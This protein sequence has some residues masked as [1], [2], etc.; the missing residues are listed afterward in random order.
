LRKFLG[1]TSAFLLAGLTLFGQQYNIRTVAGGAPIPN[2]PS[3]SNASIGNPG[4]MAADPAGNIYFITDDCVFRIDTGGGLTR[5]AGN[6]Q[7]GFSGDG[8]PAVQA[9]LNN[10]LGLAVDS[11]NNLYIADSGNNRIR[12]VTIGTGVITTIAGLATAGYTG[13]NGQSAGAA[14]NNPQGLAVDTSGNLYIADTGNNVIRKITASSAIINTIAGTGTGGQP[15]GDGGPA[16]AAQMNAPTGVSVDTTGN[17]YIADSKNNRIREVQSGIMSTIAGNGIPGFAGDFGLATSAELN[18]PTAVNWAVNGVVYLVDSANFR[19]RQ[20]M[21][22]KVISTVAG[23]GGSIPA[24]NPQGITTDAVSNL[25]VSDAT[26]FIFK[27]TPSVSIF[28]GNG[29]NYSIVDNV[30]GPS[31]QLVLPEGLAVDGTGTYIAD[32]GEARI[33]KTISG[34]NITSPPGGMAIGPAGVT[35]DGSGNMYIADASGNVVI[36]VSNGVPTTI[37]GV[38]TPGAGGDNGLATNAQLNQPNG[39]A[40][41]T[42]GNV[43]IADTLNHKI[44]KITVATGIITTIAGN[45]SPGFGG[46]NGPAIGAILNQ[47][48]GLVLDVNG[49]IYI[50]DTGNNRIRKITAA[51]AFITTLAGNGA[52]SS[53][54][55]GGAATSAAIASP[56]GVGLDSLLNLYIPDF[57]GRVRKVSVSG[58][59]TTIAGT[60]VQGYSGDNGPATNAQLNQ[61]WGIAVDGSGNVF[62]SDIGNQCVRVLTQS[63]PP[64]QLSIT[65]TSLPPGTTGIPYAQALSA[66]GGTP[67]YIWSVAIGSL[68]SGLTLSPSGSISG[69]PTGTSA[70][71]TVQVTDSSSL[72]AQATL[73][74]VINPGNANGLSITSPPTLPSAAVINGVGMPYVQAL[75]AIA[76]NPPY[77]WTLVSGTLPTGLVL[78]PSGLISGTP[79]S[80]GVFTFTLRVNDITN[81]IATQNFTLQVISSGSPA[82]AGVLGQVAAGGVWTTRTYLTNIST[83]PVV[84]NLVVHTDDGSILPLN[85]TQQGTTQAFGSNLFT[86]VMNPNSTIVVDAGAGLPN[87]VTGW[88]DVLSSG[89]SNSMAGFAVFRQT[90]NAAGAVSEGTSP[91]QTQFESRMDL[92]FDNTGS[93]NTDLAIVNLSTSATTVTATVLDSN[94]NLLGTYSLS[95]NANGHTAFLFPIQFPVSANQQGVVQFV[96]NSGSNLAG[97]GLRANTGAATGTF[98]SVPVILP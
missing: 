36:K 7:L 29:Q 46:D 3:A 80:T 85:V 12:R 31:S 20:I 92:Q 48:Y 69:T 50:A 42:A 67:P 54:G 30:P 6:S 51:T 95:L 98:T 19:V 38:G 94:G 26:H 84:V 32:R 57:T 15:T 28:A 76:G 40:V 60:G 93:F 56:H 88:M 49:N 23:A 34:G 89:A 61:P 59:I 73:V 91:L 79:Q 70:Q 96:S 64:S 44:R 37:A 27:S 74:I 13:D 22:N 25:Y 82:R 68:P 66:T 87:T 9:Q 52:Q 83:T 63:A 39:V 8:G 65:T 58:V 2:A 90:I 33:R 81:T 4:A 18:L 16:T 43:Y 1:F 77:T 21:P 24:N 86:G 78:S 53:S 71:F 11:N 5:M 47:P 55:D 62:V 17:I 35:V 45:N 41:D 14:L 10:P 75:T 72:T 97:V